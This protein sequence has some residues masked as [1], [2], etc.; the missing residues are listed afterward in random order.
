MRL[1]RFTVK[2]DFSRGKSEKTNHAGFEFTHKYG[3]DR[4][5]VIL[6]GIENEE[7]RQAESQEVATIVVGSRDNTFSRRN[8]EG[9]PGA[10]FLTKT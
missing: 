10:S 7:G 9:I 4:E 3:L 5:N 2:P 6:S 8:R 1:H